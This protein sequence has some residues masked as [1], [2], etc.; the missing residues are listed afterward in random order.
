MEEGGRRE[1]GGERMREEGNKRYE[2]R[3]RSVCFHFCS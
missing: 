3:W 1:E 2:E